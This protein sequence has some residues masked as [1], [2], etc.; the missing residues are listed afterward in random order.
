MI[1]LVDLSV[2]A[3][4]GYLARADA[5]PSL[6]FYQFLSVAVLVGTLIALILT[7]LGVAWRGGI[8]L[9]R[10]GADLKTNTAET[11]TIRAEVV[12]QRETNERTMQIATRVEE[13]VT[14]V[15]QR[16]T[17]IEQTIDRRQGSGRREGDQ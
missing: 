15:E 7:V 17:R 1:G 13:K 9:G 10:M 12:A 3:L 11:Q 5:P 8:L 2:V 4:A 6:P 16:V 14:A